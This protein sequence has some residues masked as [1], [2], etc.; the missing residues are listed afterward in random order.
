MELEFVVECLGKNNSRTV[1]PALLDAFVQLT[2]FYPDLLEKEKYM[3]C[4][5]IS[6]SM[7]N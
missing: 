1:L 6:F 5:S 3:V 2:A 4:A 7:L